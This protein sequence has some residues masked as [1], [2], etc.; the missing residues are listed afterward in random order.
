[1]LPRDLVRVRRRG[2][3]IEPTLLRPTPAVT[4]LAQRLID[5]WR[6]GL[7]RTRGELEDAAVPILHGSR[8][9]AVAKG[10]QKILLDASRFTDPEGREALRARALAASAARLRAPLGSADAHRATIAVELG[11]DAD[12]LAADLYADHPDHARLEAVP[13]WTVERWLERYNTALVQGLLLDARSVELHLAKDLARL[14]AVLRAVRFGRLVAEVRAADGGWRVAID[15]PAAVLER[16]TAYG[17]QLAQLLPAVVAV[18]GAWRL[19]ADLRRKDGAATLE[20]ESGLPLHGQAPAH[21][22]AEELRDLPARLADK[23]P[24]CEVRPGE[25]LTLGDGEVVAPDFALVHAGRT[26]QVELC[27]RWHAAVARR[28]LDQIARGLAPDLRLGIDRA[29]LKLAEGRGLDQHPA[30]A[31]QGFAFSG[32]PSPTGLKELLER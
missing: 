23:V 24:G 25:P 5:H 19:R 7:G 10:L 13:E 8:A 12:A 1:M 18:G 26:L 20:L 16:T 9:L 27:T 29:L 21:H 22:I 14:R 28:R 11:M 15:G 32:V 3:G 6:G 17:L 2:D 4:E 31:S 30:F